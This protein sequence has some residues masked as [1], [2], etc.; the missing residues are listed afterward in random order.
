MC[1]EKKENKNKREEDKQSFPPNLTLFCLIEQRKK[2][3]KLLMIWIYL[4]CVIHVLQ[5]SSLMKKGLH[6]DHAMKHFLFPFFLL[7]MNRIYQKVHRTSSHTSKLRKEKNGG[8]CFLP[9]LNSSN[10]FLIT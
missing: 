10:T 7:K 1:N 4:M 8:Y 5:L 6:I 9:L 3:E 2:G